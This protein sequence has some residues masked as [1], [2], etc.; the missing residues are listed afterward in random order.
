MW[1][2]MTRFA[3]LIAAALA[4]GLVLAPPALAQQGDDA[5]ALNAQITKLFGEGKYADAV[6][7]AQRV[8]TIR[9]KALG[10]EFS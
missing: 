7:L 8:L 1:S 4:W 3:R 2:S 9:E 10:P 6:P 5:D